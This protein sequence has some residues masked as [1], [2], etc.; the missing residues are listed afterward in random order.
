MKNMYKYSIQNA[1]TTT[2]YSRKHF[3]TIEFE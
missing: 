3:A 1:S 2:I